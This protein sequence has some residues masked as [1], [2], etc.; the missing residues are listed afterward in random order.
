MTRD[1]EGGGKRFPWKTN[2]REDDCF[3][4]NH[5]ALCGL[6]IAKTELTAKTGK[7]FI[8]SFVRS[9][10]TQFLPSKGLES[11]QRG[12]RSRQIRIESNTIIVQ[13]TNTCRTKGGM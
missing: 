11:G 13:C 10:D 4:G 5:L 3:F 2:T 12:W 6:P 9:W 1:L 7:A 8:H